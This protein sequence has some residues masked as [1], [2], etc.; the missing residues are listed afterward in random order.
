VNT[1]ENTMI[2][3]K[4]GPQFEKRVHSIIR[5]RAQ[6]LLVYDF[7]NEYCEKFNSS[8]QIAAA[9]THGGLPATRYASN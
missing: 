2:P 3:F 7:E 1:N 9:I 4:K 8:P 6:L 5:N